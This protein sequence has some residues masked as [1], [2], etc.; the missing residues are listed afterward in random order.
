MRKKALITG[1]SRGI[2][3]AIAKELARQ[4]FDLTLTCLNSLDQLKELAGGLE[5][6]YGVSCHIFQGD[7]G[8]PEA[9]DRLFDGLNRL[10]VLINNAGIS[11]IGLLSDM[12]VSQ[13]RRVM[14]TNLDSCFYTCRRAI[15]LMVHAK[16]GRIINIS[17][18]WGQAG[19]SME[20]AYSASK[21]GVN[22]LTKALAKELAPSNIQV[23][24]IACGVIDTDM[25]RCFS[26]E[27]MASLIEEIPADRIGRAE[28]V[29]A[30]AGQL[31]TAPA[32]M[33]GQIITIDGGW[34]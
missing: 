7:M 30:L 4:G 17:S 33:T 12:S 32:Y 5:K 11:H 23:N 14:S 19:A 18:V 29:A 2:G 15:P 16:Q 8:D 25:N 9:V 28:E 1:A 34:I 31:I 22:S 20:A 3:E 27:E 26:P 10:D 21:G 13:W 24:A 6:K